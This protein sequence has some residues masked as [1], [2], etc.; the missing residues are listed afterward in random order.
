MLTKLKDMVLVPVRIKRS[1]AATVVELAGAASI[2]VGAWQA[3]QPAGWLV[4][5]SFAVLGA[6]A[7]DGI[8]K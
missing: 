7:Y 5:G 1:L 2:T 4:G 6:A 3:W 8:A